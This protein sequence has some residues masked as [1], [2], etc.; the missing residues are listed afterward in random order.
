MKQFNKKWKLPIGNLSRKLMTLFFVAISF[1]ALAQVTVT[2]PAANTNSGA[3]R[4]PLGTWWGYERNAAIYTASDIGVPGTISSI[5]WYVQALA[6]PGDAP[7]EIYLKST[8]ASAFA[9][10]TTV[11]NE[12]T[13]ATLVY[14]GTILASTL[15]IDNWITIPLTTPFLYNGGAENL[16]VIVLATATGTGNEGQ[17]AKTFRYSTTT[18]V[19]TFQTWNGDNNAPTGNGTITANRPN[20]QF[21]ITPLPQSYSSS[22]VLTVT[23]AVIAV[24]TQNAPVVALTVTMNGSLTPFSLDSLVVSTN[25]TTSLT[26]ISNLKVFYTGTS[27]IFNTT[28]QYGVT[29]PT[30]VASQTVSGSQVLASGVNYFWITYDVNPTAVNNNFIDAEIPTFYLG[31]T[32]YTPTNTAPAGNR[33]IRTPLNGIYT[34]GTAGDFAN[35]TDAFVAANDLGLSGNVTFQ[36]ISDLT[37][38]APAILNEWPEVGAGNYSI[39]ITPSGGPRTI[40]GNVANSGVLVFIGADRVTVDGLNHEL[41]ISNTNTSTVNTGFLI[42]GSPTDAA[43]D[44]VIANCNIFAGSTNVS[45][46]IVGIQAQGDGVNNLS[47]LN[48]KFKRSWSAINIGYGTV[49]T[50][51]TGLLISGNTIGSDVVADKVSFGM[52]ILNATNPLITGNTI[53]H[54]YTNLGANI[55]GIDL[56]A[57]V[58]GAEVSKNKIFGLRSLSTGGWGAHGINISSGTNNSNNS[59]I[60][61]EIYDF[62]TDGDGTSTLFNPYGIR[63]TGGTNHKIYHNTVHLYGAFANLTSSDISSALMITSNTVTGLDIRNNIFSNI[64][65]GG[66]AT[67]KSYAIYAVTG[68]TFGTINYNNYYA[69]GANARLGFLGSDITTLAAWQ[70]ASTQD[71]NSLDVNPSFTPNNIVIPIAAALNDLGTPIATVFDDI[72]GNLRNVTNPDMG[73]YEFTPAACS[74]VG[75]ITGAFDITTTGA[76]IKWQHPGTSVVSYSWVVVPKDSAATYTPP[77][78]SGTVNYPQDSVVIAGLTA[79]SDYDFYITASCGASGTSSVSGNYSFSTPCGAIVGLPFLETFEANSTSR[80]CWTQEVV[81]GANLWTYNT[82]SSGGAVTTAHNGTLNARFTSSDVPID[83]NILISPIIDMT[84]INNAELSFW[85]AQQDWAG[86]QNSLF[87]YY[88]TSPTSAWNLIFADSSDVN[89][90]TEVII[91]LPSPSA[92]YQLGFKGIDAWGRANVI[93]DVLIREVYNNDLQAASIIGNFDAMCGT[94]S[95]T[96]KVEIRNSGALTHDFAVNNAT[97]NVA[98]TGA[99]T[100]NLSVT[101]NSGTLASGASQIISIPNANFSVLGAY[102]INGNISSTIDQNSSND[103]LATVN[104]TSIGAPVSVTIANNYFEGFENNNGNFTTSGVNN[105]WAWGTPNNTL[106]NAAAEGVN[107]WVTNLTGTYTNNSVSYITSPCFDMSSVQH[108]PVLFFQQI[109]ELENCCDETWVDVSVDGGDTWTKLGTSTSGLMNWYNDAANNWFDSNQTTWDTSAHVLTGFSGIAKA[110]LRFVFSSDVSSVEEGW[111][112]DDIMIQTIN[113]NDMTVL[114]IETADTCGQNNHEFAVT[115]KNLGYTTQSN[116]PVAISFTGAQTFTGTATIPGPLAYNQSATVVVNGINTL[117]GGTLDLNAYTSLAVDNDVNNDSLQITAFAVNPAPV[118]NLGADT[119]ICDGSTLVVDAGN[120]GSTY[121]WSDT[122]TNQTFDITEV[123]TV[124]V[125]VTSAFGCVGSDTINVSLNVV[126]DVD[127]GGDQTVCADIDVTLDAGNPGATYNWISGAQ[128]QTIDIQNSGVYSVI[129]TDNNGCQ[130][131]DTVNITINPLPVV[132]LGADRFEQVGTTV[133][134]DAG[135]AGST[136]DWNTGATTQTIDVV[137]PGG[138]YSVTVTNMFNCVDSDTITVNF[139]VGTNE[140]DASGVSFKAYPNPSSGNVQL[141]LTNVETSASANIEVLD[142]T[143]RVVLNLP[144]GQVSGNSNRNINLENH[145]K[146][147]YTIRLVTDSKVF[148]QTILLQ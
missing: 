17:F 48:N 39:T 62:I 127:L 60:N 59:I 73:A 45:G 144:I 11:A 8:T 119:V 68:T 67:T 75:N 15:S 80:D 65:T 91:S 63:I 141:S 109:R 26:D 136:Y 5:G 113:P 29:I 4:Q 143:G 58:S 47:I 131:F 28:T 27:N 92:S 38:T 24:G 134:L 130:G 120:A 116:I 78:A 114:N 146:G 126:P 128:T 117:S 107:A 52:F 124:W 145:A 74:P 108:D 3:Q 56:G 104:A 101:L 9:A 79:Q 14:S 22:D 54:L 85:Y 72:A 110:R 66:G 106:I 1:S 70:T 13:G 115:V 77:I 94:N 81:S 71:L 93:D 40:S 133:T 46:T 51:Y 135:N 83:T 90:W 61:N 82:G 138:T 89:V 64:M 7:I 102:T 97:I 43:E 118:V 111:G 86:D 36:I 87:V 99:A 129:V 20:I 122:T 50:P 21:E 96:L 18:G 69:G 147:L 34:V 112:V 121:L 25:G 42:V 148:V 103:T 76:T 142:L 95:D 139:N 23:P 132:S 53:Q 32:P 88:R 10:G 41:T 12:L 16:E 98:I 35:I 44:I 105:T 140:V 100:S 84:G 57:N 55:S 33:Q 125:E 37:V 31:S 30:P 49:N 19:N 2:V 123:S 6:T 137:S